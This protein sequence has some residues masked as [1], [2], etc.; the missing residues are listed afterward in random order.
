MT[1]WERE[2]ME[3]QSL[4][5]ERAARVVALDAQRQKEAAEAR[6]RQEAW[7][8]E[9]EVR[10]AAEEAARQERL[11]EARK[12]QEVAAKRGRAEVAKR[13][14]DM[15]VDQ[16]RLAEE[17]ERV[18]Q[19]KENRETAL[20]LNRGDGDDFAYSFE[21]G[22]EKKVKAFR[23]RGTGGDALIIKIDHAANE[24]R[25]DEQFKGLGSAEAF[26]E[27]LDETEPRYLLYIHKVVHNDGRTSYPIAFL[28]FMPETMPPHLKV[29]YT[30][31]VVTLTDTFK[32][33]KH[34]PLEDAED[35][36]D[37]WLEEKLGVVK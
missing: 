29:M 7:R 24:L 16:Q 19:A 37:E 27:K 26:A 2:Q 10:A 3:M 6:A 28:V 20:K 4:E 15:V 22:M 14:Q 8:V 35:M 11:V 21:E 23:Q 32:V 31:P 5:D 33:P 30:R 9:D 17:T 25:I 13:E 36:T 1:L 12:A 34:I 18:R